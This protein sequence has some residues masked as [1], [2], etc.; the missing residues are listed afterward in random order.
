LH[1][2]TGLFALVIAYFNGHTAATCLFWWAQVTW[3]PMSIGLLRQRAAFRFAVMFPE[4]RWGREAMQAMPA[5]VT[6]R[7]K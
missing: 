7:L 2:T 5:R 1:V 4:S 6:K 3:V